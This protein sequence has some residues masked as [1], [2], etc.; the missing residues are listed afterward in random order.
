MPNDTKENR[1]ALQK[2]TK[3]S[4]HGVEKKTAS[5]EIRK[6]NTVI[7]NRPTID[8]EPGTTPRIQERKGVPAVRYPYMPKNKPAHQKDAR[9]KRPFLRRS[10]DGEDENNRGKRNPPSLVS[11][12]ELPLVETEGVYTAQKEFNQNFD[13]PILYSN[14]YKNSSF[15]SQNGFFCKL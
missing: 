6:G 10:R 1:N 2:H 12:A 15:F 5:A 13:T 7:P 3:S 14:I 9:S 4:S 11:Y 8:T